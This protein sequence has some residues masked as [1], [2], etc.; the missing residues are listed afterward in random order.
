MGRVRER[1]RTVEFKNKNKQA[2]L[3]LTKLS[4]LVIKLNNSDQMVTLWK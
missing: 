1:K 4:L 3:N 2:F